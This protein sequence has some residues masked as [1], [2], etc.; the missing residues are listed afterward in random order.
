MK[1]I[2]CLLA[3][4]GLAYVAGPLVAAKKSTSS[5]I[6][7]NSKVGVRA[8]VDGS[9]KYNDEC[10]EAY[11]GCMDQFCIS[12][13]ES[14]GTCICSSSYDQYEAKLKQIEK[15]T[16]EANRKSTLEVEKIKAGAAA[17]ILFT[18]TRE[19][20]KSGNVMTMEK[21]EKK[22]ARQRSIE[23]MMGGDEE[24]E[25][26]E[27]EFSMEGL[28]GKNLYEK[29]RQICLEQVGDACG[30]T[31]NMQTQRYL[32]QVKSDCTALSKNI[33]DLLKKS[34]LAIVEAE[35]DI[36]TARKEMVDEVNK[37]NR[38]QCVVEFKKCM[39]TEDAC[40]KDWGRCAS[41]IAAENMQNNAAKSTRGTKVSH[42]DVFDI[43]DSTKEM[44]ES[45]RPVCESVLDQCQAVRD[46]VWND[47]L[48]DIAPELK[49]AESKLE[50]N[51]R[52]SCLTDISDCIQKACKD[53]IVGKGKETMDS[54]L[55]RPDMAR[56]FCKIEI[57]PCERMEPQIWDYVVSKLAAMRVDVCTQEVKDCFTSDD[58]CGADFGK[59]LGM[60][61]NYLHE[62]CPVDKLV[63]CKQSKKNFEM[64]DI[65]N[66]LMGFYLNIDN[67][68]LDLCQQKIDEKM[69]DVCGSTTDCNRF[70]ADNNLGIGSLQSIKDGDI[71]RITGMLSFGMI[72]MG[73]GKTCD[74]EDETGK[75]AKKD[76]LPYGK[77]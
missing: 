18:G 56:S 37:Y 54:C 34:E 2:F 31:L 67:S 53:D 73:D 59:C 71:Y 55:A 64:S 51:K 47:F 9:E 49:I 8:K 6:V 52:Q 74:G 10:Y 36:T 4:C 27:D 72:K 26:E 48:R 32:T 39:M 40:G 50:S 17:D 70:A 16:D 13:N 63:V 12:D 68:A 61:Y 30:N 76:I 65:D 21:V 15:N 41:S 14:G 62:M 35:K 44:L 46:V 5:A 25:E 60:D 1:R 66:M 33:D 77:I 57:D 69:T 29:A 11:F 43:T 20:D 42:T 19:Y 45:K 3:V 24:E 38:G 28:T 75:C 7:T 23:E 58:R 22:R